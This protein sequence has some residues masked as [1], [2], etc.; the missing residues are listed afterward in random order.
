M[1]SEVTN[2]EQE[3][4]SSQLGTKEYWDKQYELEKKNFDEIG[5]KGEV[6]FGKAAM[7]RMVRWLEKKCQFWQ[8]YCYFNHSKKNS[9][10]FSLTFF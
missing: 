3:L 10:F 8:R 1:S 4:P 7:N 5:D 2:E 6:W 9:E